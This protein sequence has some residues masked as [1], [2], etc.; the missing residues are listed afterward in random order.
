MGSAALSELARRG[1]TVLGL[2]RFGP[3]HDRGSSHGRSRII[4]EAY[5][6]GELYVPIIQRAYELWGELEKRTGK[7]VL[8]ETGLL[9]IGEPDSAFISGTLRS[10]S[11]HNLRCEL[12]EHHELCSRYPLFHPPEGS[13]GVVDRRGALLD[14]ELCVES[15]LRE[16]QEAS[17][18]VHFDTRVTSW[19][20]V[21][22]GVEVTTGTGERFVGET[23]ILTPGAWLPELA[24]SLPLTVARQVLFWF[25]PTIPISNFIPV[26]FPLF[27]VDTPGS[28]GLY[29]FPAQGDS[30][31]GVKVALHYRYQKTAPESVDRVVHPD[32]VEVMR[33]ILA[34]YIPSLGGRL[35]HAKTCLYTLTPDEHFIIDRH[36]EHLRVLLVSACSGHGFKFGSAIGEIVA[37]LTTIGRTRFDITPFSLDRFLVDRSSNEAPRSS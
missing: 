19:R 32:E 4:R 35:L 29:G 22:N 1:A 16:A 36:P 7:K 6:E 18:T 14:P 24:P 11:L 9:L 13:V 10:A 31:E 15:Y 26:R 5:A 28:E 27:L 2:D 21:D 12:L 25:E 8:T 30:S 33:S 34:R 23:L 20:E 17:A 3:A 37:D